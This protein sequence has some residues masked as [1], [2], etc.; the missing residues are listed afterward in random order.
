[1]VKKKKA[2]KKELKLKLVYLREIERNAILHA[3]QPYEEKLAHLTSA[4]A[5]DVV[6]KRAAMTLRDMAKG[7]DRL[8]ESRKYSLALLGKFKKLLEA[9]ALA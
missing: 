3:L 8:V 2:K 1:M 6:L 4:E 7:L 9:K 5:P